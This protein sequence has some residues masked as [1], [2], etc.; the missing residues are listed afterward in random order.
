MH[1]P[2]YLATNKDYISNSA[3]DGLPYGGHNTVN[4]ETITIDEVDY[5]PFYSEFND[6]SAIIELDNLMVWIGGADD[7]PEDVST[8]YYASLL[9]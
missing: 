1:A 3:Y 6:A 7:M 8:D 5:E 2:T 9:G 4:T